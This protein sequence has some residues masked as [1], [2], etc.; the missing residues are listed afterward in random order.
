MSSFDFLLKDFDTETYYPMAREMEKLYSVGVYSSELITARKIGEKMSRDILDFHFQN[1]PER[2]TFNDN[3]Y[4]IKGTNY[5]SP[6]MLDL[7]FKLKKGGNESAHSEKIITK[8][9]GLKYLKYTFVLLADFAEKYG[10]NLKVDRT[11]FTIPTF[12]YSTTSSKKLIY[13]VSSPWAQYKGLEKVG[14]TTIPDGEYNYTPDSPDLRKAAE[15]RIK[16][17]MKTAGVPFNLE[18]TEL[19]RRKDGT[20]FDDHD[21]HR[22]LQNSGYQQAGAQLAGGREFYRINTDTAKKAIA[23]VKNGLTAIEMPAVQKQQQMNKPVITLRPEQKQ[24]VEKT[25]KAFKH[26]SKMLWNAKMRFGKTITALSLIKQE[27]YQ[28]V[29]IMTHRPVVN[30]GWFQDFGKVGMAE[31]GYNYGSKTRGHTT[32]TELERLGQ[33]YVYFASIQDLRGSS[34]V[35]GKVGDKNQDIFS[36]KWD[37]VIIDEA[38]EGTQTELAQN[39]VTE[40]LKNKKDCK[41]LE[42]SGTPFNLLEDYDEDQIFTWDYTMEQEA[43][44]KWDEEHPDQPNPYAGLPRVLMFTFEMNKDFKDPEFQMGYTGNYSF[45]FKDFFRVDDN[46]KFIHENYVRQFIK[47]ITTPGK[48]NYPFSTRQFRNNLRHTLWILPGIRECNALE[49]LLNQPGNVFYDEG[50]KIINVV[51]G[52][53]STD[54]E[55]SAS[56]LDRVNKAMGPDPAETKTITLTVRKMTTGVTIKPWTGVMFLSNISSAMQYLQAAFRAQT[57]YSSPTFGQKENCYVFDFAPDRALNVMAEATSLSTKPGKLNDPDR[58]VKM[59]KLLQFLPIIGEKGQSMSPY[60]VNSLLQ[61]V[62]HIYAERAVRTGFDD[63]SIYSDALFNITQDNLNEFNHLKAIVGTTKKEKAATKVDVNKQGLSTKEAEDAKKARVKKPHERTPEEQ[64]AYEK[65]K[66]LREQRR[67]LISILRGVSIRIPM[68]IYGMDIKF[69]EDVKISKFVDMVDD[70]SWTEFMPKG[71]TKELFKEFIKFY[72][73]NVFIE[74]G[75]IIRSKVKA[76]DKEDPL[77]RVEKIAEIFGGFKNPDKETVLT[78]WRV[79]NLHLGKTIG[80]LVYFDKD[81]QN[82]Y[83]DGHSA[84]H[85]EVNENTKRVYHPDTRV[86]EINSKTG[87]YPLFV[88]SS[89]YYQEF[90]KMNEQKAGKFSLLDEQFIWQKILRE[91]LFIVAKTPMAKQI[92]LRTLRGYHDDWD[93]NAEYVENIVDDAKLN[94]R[95]EAEKIERMFGGMKFDVVVGNPPYQEMGKGDND[96]YAA[97]IY[98]NFMDLSYQL[99]D[100]VT[101][102]TPARF[103]FNAGSTPKKWNQKMLND[104]HFKVIMYE[105]KSA[106]IFPNTD[107]KGG[108][109]ITLRDTSQEFEP[110]ETFTPYS[111]LNS[112]LKK[113]LKKFSLG[114]LSEIISGRNIYKLSE[115]AVKDHPEL[116]SLQSK[117]HQN[118]IGSGAFKILKDIIFFEDKPKDGHKYAELL[119]M[120]NRNRVYLWAR[121]DYLSVPESFYKYKIFIPEA[122][123]SGAIGEVLSTPLIGA[124]LIGATDTFISVGPFEDK[125]TAEHVLKYIKT[126]FARTMLGVKKATQHNPRSTWEYVPLQDFTSNSDI[127]WSKSITEIDQQLYKKYNLTKDEINFIETKVQAM[128]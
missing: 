20:I 58:E 95:A 55:A 73:A 1:I 106:N 104:P 10:D 98:H 26:Y 102:I 88:A 5:A 6:E 72:D 78:P 122:N 61:R 49:D 22:V 81:Y 105:A 111:E 90:N 9:D 41:L 125:N 8:D 96:N 14:E 35:G 47:N 63:D 39:V 79:V 31:A 38:H 101:L 76:L 117:G 32:V 21:V 37:L 60:N 83:V 28:K 56:D 25:V 3:L 43:K 85:W 57:P 84:M 71:V 42:L 52:D 24:A 30:D 126:K 116:T 11:S 2:A 51:R 33:P 77:N 23:A 16:Q 110:I 100:L 115:L 119:G 120:E 59:K 128:E 68:M 112:I 74:A 127:D 121:I 69:D 97:P 50:Y 103:L 94:V 34:E 36:N 46:G 67:T 65:A 13:V 7:L 114:S 53:A 87:L 15:D 80:G 70:V 75:R 64:A 107:I 109:A 118:D 44:A 91:N 86:L 4:R 54:L 113:V 48:N 27:S 62:K 40:V 123:G 19:A 45:N 18:W 124:P 89:L 108:V 12:D 17:Y 29:L 66:A 82:E 92:A 93:V 99:S